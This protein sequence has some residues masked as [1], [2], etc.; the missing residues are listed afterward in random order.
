MQSIAPLV[1]ADF[2][3]KGKTTLAKFEVYSG[4]AWQ[5]MCAFG[6]PAKNY[7]VKDSLQVNP[8][9]PQSTPDIKGGTWS[10]QVYNPG[11]MFHRFHPTSAYRDYFMVGTPVRISL[12]ARIGGTDY[13]YQRLVGYINKRG[14][15][16]RGRIVNLSGDDYTKTLADTILAESTATSGTINGPLHWGAVQVFDSISSTGVTG[17]EIYAENDAAEIGAGEADAVGAWNG[18]LEAYSIADT[19]GGSTYALQFVRLATSSTVDYS[20]N[21]DVGSVVVGEQYYLSLG[22]KVVAGSNWTLRIYQTVGGALKSVGSIGLGSSPTWGTY[23]I[24]FTAIKTGALELRVSQAKGSANDEVRIDQ[25][26]IK[27]YEPAWYRYEMPAGC[28]GPYYVTL[29]GEQIVMGSRDKNGH[30]DG[31]LYDED[32]LYFYFDQ[33]RV[34]EN[35]TDNLL[36]Y[37][38]IA[39]APENVVADILVYCGLYATRAAALAAMDYTATGITIPRVWFDD[40]TTA[41][42]AL[43]QVCERVNYRFWFAYDGTP[44]FKPA[45]V[46]GTPVF[47][48]ENIGDIQYPDDDENL[49]RVKNHVVIVGAD[50]AM[51]STNPDKKEDRYTAEAEDATSIAASGRCTETIKNDLYQT[52][53]ACAAMAAAILA[54]RK[55]ACWT[56]QV[57]AGFQALPIEV[58]DTIR[59]RALLYRPTG[60]LDMGADWGAAAATLDLGKD[61]AEQNAGAIDF[62]DAWS[63]SVE[64]ILTGIVRE[65]G[66]VGLQVTYTVDTVLP[67]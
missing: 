11:G 51:F 9:G 53:A 5:D 27:S 32:D 61:W 38:Y 57:P 21:S 62:G 43:A 10:C 7:L 16:G 58:G 31:Y 46:E 64:V 60:T 50:R 48:F 44:C 8:S 26:S 59:W 4:G 28:E 35:G 47:D 54:E 66:I 37:H 19:G 34:V 2:L 41:I 56:T 65:I 42:K 49:E 14:Y 39:Q 40:G 6:S 15:T 17:A 33:D 63:G 12:G 13:Y 23:D 67:A 18:S 36:V 29:D 20:H 55:D 45:P 25:I 52:D 1:N 22:V 30:F 24:V 3:A